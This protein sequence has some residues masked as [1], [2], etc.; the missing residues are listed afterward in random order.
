MSNITIS[1]AEYQKLRQQAVSYQK[2]AK[3]LF[4][5]IIRVPVEEV[6]EDFRKTDLYT[7]DFLRDS[8]NGLRKSSYAKTKK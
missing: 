1:K 3:R 4:E 6:V 8:E 2:L 7:E 5:F